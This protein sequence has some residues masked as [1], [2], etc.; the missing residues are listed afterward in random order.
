VTTIGV[1]VVDDS[2][3]IRRMVSS[4]LDDDPDITVVGTASNGRIALDKLA[5]LRPDIVILDVE[6][7]VMDGLATLRAL[8]L[9]H[10]KL[11]V[12]M[13]SALTERGATA[14]LDALAAGA[15]DYVTKPSHAGSVAASIERVRLE[16]IPKVKG[17]VGANRARTA[18][19]TA[20][21]VPVPALRPVRQDRVDVIAVGCSTGGPDALTAIVT[22]LPK[23]FAKPVLVVQH[24]PALFTRLFAERLNRSCPLT[25]TEATDGQVVQ[26]GH[27]I[28]APGDRHLTV[29]RQGTEIVVVLGQE[30]PE[31]Y[32]RPSVDVMFRSVADIYGGGVLACVLTGMGHDGASGAARIRAVGGRIVVQD[33]ASSVVWGM[34][35][36]VVAAG[37]ATDIVPLDRIAE[38]LRN[39]VIPGARPSSGRV[40]P[41]SAPR[42]VG[43]AMGVLASNRRVGGGG[44]A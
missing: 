6:M 20:P 25:V 9:T 30:P 10:P 3:V 36:S 24:M 32:C 39:A 16:L 38:T 19:S 27:I 17:L 41:A 1:L 42:A 35:G 33:E 13:F 5:Q 14:T 11:P 26:A 29:R 31:N 44:G 22:G 7:P 43:P 23:D 4:V 34:P 18:P 40:L 12:V 15:T 8:R 37:L 28:V 21:V 2:V